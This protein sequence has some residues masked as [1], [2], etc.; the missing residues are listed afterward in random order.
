MS[1]YL[2]AYPVSAAAPPGRPFFL[3]PLDP[4]PPPTPP[5]T[6][7]GTPRMRFVYK[8]YRGTFFSSVPRRVVG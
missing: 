3:L 6:D 7:E 5:L 1:I 8:L 4:S 2:R